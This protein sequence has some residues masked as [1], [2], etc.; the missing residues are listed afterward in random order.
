MLKL[1]KKS[2]FWFWI[3]LVA[4][5]SLL[6][7]LFKAPYFTHHDDVQVIRLHQ[8]HECIKDG[9]IPCRWVPDLGGLYGY[10]LFNYYGPIPYY[11]GEGVYL[12]SGSFIFSAKVMF[13]L[14]F[15]GAYL[16]MYLLARKLWGNELAG[17]LAAIFYS[18]APYHALDFYVRGAMGEMWALM[19]FPA[20]F[21]AVL[22]LEENLEKKNI[23]ILAL[24]FALLIASH[25]ISAM[26]FM[27]VLLAF[28]ILI[29]LRERKKN[30]L[31]FSIISLILGLTLS[32]F[33]WLPAVMEKNLVHVE[34]TTVGYFSYTEH[35]KGFRKLFLERSW[36]WGPSIREVPG[37]EKD[38]MSYQ[39]GWVH[40][41]LWGL[42]LVG[43][44]RLKKKWSKFMIL[45]LTLVA[46]GA[47]YLVN[48]RAVYVWN[49]LSPLKYLQFPWRF[50]MLVIFPVSLLTGSVF[51]WLKR[52]TAKSIWILAVAAV[53]IFNFSYFRPEKFLQVSEREYLTGELWEKQIKRSIF[54]YLPIYAEMPPAE[55]ASKRY[56]VLEGEAEIRDFREGSNWFKFKI[57]VKSPAQVRVS[58]YYFPGWKVFSGDKELKIDYQNE[59]GLIT[60]DLE[61]GTHEVEGKLFN[62]PT[63]NIANFL[64]LFSV[65]GSLALLKK[66]NV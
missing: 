53:V 29:F 25:N 7:P 34:T 15:V 55:L 31:L 26:I 5:L 64:S 36:N 4:T 9:Q 54:D 61:S 50:L 1:K 17:S 56:E 21:W 30:F 57:D 18:F 35:F 13:A 46:W 11:F 63:R 23:V 44:W 19:L 33:Y 27:P 20:I 42:A 8:M 48:P 45:F 3:G 59:L 38:A 22:K 66:K 32:A 12:L 43:L 62:T 41:A 16:F 51:L 14:A 49:A 52:K 10:P 40:T 58:A 47:A 24:F 2:N 65:L 60:F 39:I 6:W 37:G 28:I